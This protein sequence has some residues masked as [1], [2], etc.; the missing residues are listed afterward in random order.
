MGGGVGWGVCMWGVGGGGGGGERWRVISDEGIS[1]V[2]VKVSDI[3]EDVR[4]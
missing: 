3:I 4:D 1:N 2:I